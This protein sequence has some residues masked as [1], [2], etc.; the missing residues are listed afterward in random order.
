MAKEFT[1]KFVLERLI[2]YEEEEGTFED[3]DD[4]EE[5]DTF[6][7]IEVVEEDRERTCPLV[8]DLSLTEIFPII[9]SPSPSSSSLTRQSSTLC[10]SKSAAHISFGKR[11]RTILSS[12][13]ADERAE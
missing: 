5:D 1:F 10:P 2:V 13:R 6:D 4:A 11:M 12:G 9:F 3:F 8:F 7:E